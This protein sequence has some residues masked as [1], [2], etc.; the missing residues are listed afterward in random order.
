MAAPHGRVMLVLLLAKT[1]LV[2]CFSLSGSVDQY[3]L[4]AVA[5]G[6]GVIWAGAFSVY[7]PF[8]KLRTNQFCAAMGV[9][10]LWAAGSLLL[11]KIQNRPDDNV[12]GFVFFMALPFVM[13][14]GW[15]LTDMRFRWYASCKSWGNVMQVRSGDL[16][17]QSTVLLTRSGLGGAA[18][19]SIARAGGARTQ[20]CRTSSGVRHPSRG[21]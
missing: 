9:S 12:A 17:V 21:A 8:Y 5:L 18:S 11:G 1:L 19:A 4:I 2:G 10:F 6:V 16:A 20:A 3:I 14:F 15:S 7:L 13:F